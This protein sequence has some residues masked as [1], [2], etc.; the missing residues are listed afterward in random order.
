MAACGRAYS[1]QVPSVQ[2]ETVPAFLLCLII[3]IQ[4]VHKSFCPTKYCHK[5]F[6]LTC[7]FSHTV[8]TLYRISVIMTYFN[9]FTTLCICF[10]EH[11]L[12]KKDPYTHK[13][14]SCQIST[15][16]YFL[17]GRGNDPYWE[18]L[19]CRLLATLHCK[20]R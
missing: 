18:L 8:V 4:V 13:H 7:V 16:S 17:G 9:T 14:I 10:S 19:S 6:L 2:T 3:Y 15:P 1:L 11:S 12:A 5:C 20:L